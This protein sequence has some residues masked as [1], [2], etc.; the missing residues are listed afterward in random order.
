MRSLAAKA[1]KTDLEWLAE[2]IEK[3]IIKPVIDRRYPLNKTAD[4]M[5]YLKQGHPTGKVVISILP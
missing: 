1:N 4:A 2:F 3:G 5:S